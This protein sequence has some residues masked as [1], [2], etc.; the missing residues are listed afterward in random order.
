[1]LG[2]DTSVVDG[3]VQTKGRDPVAS[4]L[5]RVTRRPKPLD[6]YPRHPCC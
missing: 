6:N 3:R 1:V 2:P 5:V 4:V